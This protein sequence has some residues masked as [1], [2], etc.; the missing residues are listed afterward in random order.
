MLV[1][2]VKQRYMFGWQYRV[3]DITI[4]A[5]RLESALL[6][7]SSWWDLSCWQNTILNCF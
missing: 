7:C 4:T 5:W 3:F 6:Y 1:L 2:F